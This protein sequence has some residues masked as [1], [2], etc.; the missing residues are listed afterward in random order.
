MGFWS[1]FLFGAG[2]VGWMKMEAEKERRKE[3]EREMYRRI[4]A[5]SD[6]IEVLKI[7]YADDYDELGRAF[8]RELT[9]MMDAIDPEY[10]PPHIRKY[11]YDPIRQG[12]DEP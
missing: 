6:R 4:M 9:P 1:K 11:G 8:K 2:V 12:L 7:R 3:L 5:V 10:L